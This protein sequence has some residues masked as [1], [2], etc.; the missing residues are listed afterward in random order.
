MTTE[1]DLGKAVKRGA[2]LRCPCCGEG[3]LFKRYLKVAPECESCGL[4]FTPQ[5][6]DDGPAY[7][8]IL[9]VCHVLGVVLHLTYEYFLENPL[10][11]ALL[12]SVI[13]VGVS[14]AAL[15]VVK[16][17]IIAFQWAKGMHG[18]GERAQA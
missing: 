2:M 16:G 13:S 10:L 15:P 9:V 17:A 18:F 1:R 14:L 5:R 3:H 12:L 4:D 7:I 11:L 8:V 6:A